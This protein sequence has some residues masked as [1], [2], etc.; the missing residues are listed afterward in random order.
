MQVDIN[1]INY[2]IIYSLLLSLILAIFSP[3]IAI[4]EA[5]LQPISNFKIAR[6]I[7]STDTTT[8]SGATSSAKEVPHRVAKP[9]SKP[10]GK[11][12][13]G[14]Y[15]DPGKLEKKGNAFVQF[16]S[17]VW[18]IIKYIFYLALVLAIGFLAIYGIKLLTNKYNAITGSGAELVNILEIRYL[19]PGKAICLVEVADKVLA[20]GLSGSSIN[21]L[22]EFTDAGQVDGLKKAAA[23][24][25]EPLQPFQGILEKFTK[26]IA[27][28][29]QTKTAKVVRKR[30][31]TRPDS[32]ME[33]KDDLYSTG[34][35][36][37]KLLDEIKEHERKSKGSGPTS[38]RDRGEDKK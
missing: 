29:P 18:D 27:N 4:A 34:D 5:K 6:S 10:D 32:D 22:S 7:I 25:P 23:K 35:S 38:K 15:E 17:T 8:S 11:F 36:I 26:R 20:L 13:I 37:R 24:K 21:L 1:R 2:L 31:G 3:E 12:L 14:K 16:I 9:D 28:Q 19:A 30:H 33:W